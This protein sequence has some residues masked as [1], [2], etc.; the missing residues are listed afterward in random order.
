MKDNAKRIIIIVSILCVLTVSLVLLINHKKNSE[1]EDYTIT[2]ETN[3]GEQIDIIT[4]ANGEGLPTFERIIKEGYSFFGWYIDSEFTVEFTE[5]NINDNVTLYAKWIPNTYTVNYNTSGGSDIDSVQVEYDQLIP[6][7]EITPTK[8]RYTFSS[9]YIDEELTTQLQ[10]HTVGGTTTIYAGWLDKCGVEFVAN[11]GSNVTNMLLDNG[12]YVILPEAPTKTNYIFLG[13][14][15]DI[16]CTQLFDESVPVTDS[17]ILYAS[18]QLITH[19]VSFNTNGGTVVSDVVVA[20]N[21]LLPEITSPT[22]TE[23]MFWSWCTDIGGTYEFDIF[24]PITSDITLYAKWL[25]YYTITFNVNGGTRIRALKVPQ[26][27]TATISDSITK[28]GYD[29]M[30][31]FYDASFN[32]IYEEEDEIASDI[33]LY[34]KWQ[35]SEY[36]IVFD[37]NGGGSYPNMTVL[38]NHTLSLPTP[39]KPNHTFEGW[40]SDEYTFSNR[41]GST[42]LITSDFTLYAE[43]WMNSIQ[44]EEEQYS[45]FGEYTG[46]SII[47]FTPRLVNP[48]YLTTQNYLP[49]IEL[50]DVLYLLNV[51]D[52][53]YANQNANYAYISSGTEYWDI[54]TINLQADINTHSLMIYNP[55]VYYKQSI[56]TT[57]TTNALRYV[58]ERADREYYIADGDNWTKYTQIHNL[59]NNPN[60]PYA[61]DDFP[62]AGC[63]WD[64]GDV[65]VTTE[66]D[67]QESD[68]I[69][70]RTHAITDYIVTLTSIL[71]NENL[72]INAE[73]VGGHTLYTIGYEIDLETQNTRDLYAYFARK[74]LREKTGLYDLE[75]TSHIATMQIWDNGLIK[76]YNTNEIWESNISIN[77]PLIG[78]RTFE[79][80]ASSNMQY[81]YSWYPTDVIIN[82]YV[83]EGIIE[84][85]SWINN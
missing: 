67:P 1:T 16:S 20:N 43:W 55:S 22:K 71:D 68:P 76:S 17:I 72:F 28:M 58:L 18:W 8:S 54:P 13:W 53:N 29:F 85:F 34:A 19:I 41:V 36:D 75:I 65:V 12:S 15:I 82:N 51:A 52:E 60:D 56:S 37:S 11:G 33:S 63:N 4:L 39:S 84:D 73:Y 30:G 6:I 62:Y 74:A 32:I 57:N 40:Y 49:D 35:I 9:W 64:S 48:N 21:D 69:V 50:T 46:T 7:P 25:S 59:L 23:Q 14:C 77:L 42:T 27:T 3:C 80:Y 10:G 26:D 61:K 47:D 66:L 79:S 2:F 81:N 5:K 78:T 44:G 45:H 31:W 83:N 70:I 24:T 38:Y